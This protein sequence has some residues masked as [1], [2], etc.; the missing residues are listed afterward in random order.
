MKTI[1]TALVLLAVGTAAAS[2]PQLIGRRGCGY[3][4]ENTAEAYREAVR[5]GYP[6]MEGHVRVTAD[7][8]FVTAHDGKTTRLGGHMKIESSSL[9]WLRTEVYTQ[10]R[11]D[12]TYTG[13]TICT[14]EEYLD[15]CSQ[16]GVTPVLHLKNLSRDKAD[17]S[18]LVPLTALIDVKGLTDKA[19]VLTSSIP[20]VEWMLAE[21]PDVK[22]MLQ[23]DERWEEL[24][25]WATERNLDV[26]IRA[27]LVDRE[28]VDRFHSRDCK[29]CV[30]TVNT[31]DELGRVADAGVDYVVT[32]YLVP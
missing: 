29:V 32:D 17:C 22:V 27:D 26:Q 19:V 2:T 8:V 30:W 21:R 20:Y 5:R 9:D 24:F 31:P 14:V 28:C 11:Q 10:E 25:D 12:T 3:A 23:A 15:I 4:I 6:M 13:S 16:S 18:M 1:L 7:S